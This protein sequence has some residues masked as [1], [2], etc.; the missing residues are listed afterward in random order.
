VL[1]PTWFLDNFTTGSFAS[2]IDSGELRLPA[3]TG[4]IPFIDTRDIAEVAVAA[5]TADGPSGILEL[6][7]PEA[8]DHAQV[9]AAL[10]TT[11]GHPI[12]YNDVPIDAF[13]THMTTRGFPHE[14]AQFLADAL[15][16]VAT[17]ALTIPVRRPCRARPLRDR[18]IG[19]HIMRRPRGLVTAIC[20]QSVRQVRPS[21]RVRM[22]PPQP[23]P[24]GT[25]S[26]AGD[27]TQRS[28]R[29]R[30]LQQMLLRDAVAMT[31]KINSP[32]IR[33]GI[34]SRSDMCMR[35]PK[36][37]VVGGDAR[38]TFH[39][40]C[41]VACGDRF[42]DLP[43]GVSTVL[44]QAVPRAYAFSIFGDCTA[45]E[46]INASTSPVARRCRVPVS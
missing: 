26:V 21:T 28:K 9:A 37:L 34:R 31:A 38:S 44:G 18:R 1:R 13:I 22:T 5:M 6:T 36:A 14:Y 12:S 4:R 15:H 32:I 7:G 42:I 30:R 19:T 40:V 17:G 33:R 8:I 27:S 11:L 29:R 10:S 46:L 23:L 24:R 35:G 3:G 16:D 41:D 20:A 43:C 39:T 45:A 2:M 25:R